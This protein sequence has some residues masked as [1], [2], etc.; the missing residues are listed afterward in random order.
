MEN[1][2]KR[3]KAADEEVFPEDTENYI[4][5]SQAANLKKRLISYQNQ[6]E[7]LFQERLKLFEEDNTIE[8]KY[9]V[10]L[11]NVKEKDLEIIELRQRLLG[12][13]GENIPAQKDRTSTSNVQP[14]IHNLVNLELKRL[15]D[16]LD[17]KDKNMAHLIR[18][19]E[20]LKIELERERNLKSDIKLEKQLRM[21][22]ENLKLCEEAKDKLKKECDLIFEAKNQEINHMVKNISDITE[23]FEN[24]INILEKDIK[25]LRKERDTS[26]EL[27]EQLNSQF[28]SQNKLMEDV[29]STL[30]VLMLE[31]SQL[32]SQ[33]QL[34]GTSDDLSSLYEAFETFEKKYDEI[35]KKVS[36]KD[37]MMNNLKNEKLKMEF[38][39]SQINRQLDLQIS[40]YKTSNAA[41][42]IS[43]NESIERENRLRQKII[44]VE[45]KVSSF[46][47]YEKNKYTESRESENIP[48]SRH[49]VEDVSKIKS[50]SHEIEY[51]RSEVDSSRKQLNEFYLN[52]GV[53]TKELKDQ[54]DLY[55][56]LLKC[57]SCKTRDKNAVIVKCMH[58]F[59]R[60]CLDTRIETRQRKCPNCGEPFG[61]GDIRNIFL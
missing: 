19:Y 46:D 48:V 55:K 8:E 51:L 18:D 38:D 61:Q 34:K 1:K 37:E 5:S 56:K 43:L 33:N 57:N 60:V 54:V 14:D 25:R 31:N 2:T 45:E 23:K 28:S 30:S 49:P 15:R 3:L 58:V 41:L 17:S 22:H 39:N 7:F 12:I 26:R 53:N 6:I 29:N 44:Q 35:L 9:Q 36:E 40:K 27:Y 42:N 20:L 21:T 11:D 10:I 24:H 50:L 4:D 52:G 32:R 59:C 13:E 16:S 47:L